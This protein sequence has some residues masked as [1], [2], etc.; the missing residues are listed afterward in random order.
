[1]RYRRTLFTVFLV[2]ATLSRA[3][4][5][6]LAR[7]VHKVRSN[8]DG[9]SLAFRWTGLY[10]GVNVGGAWGQ[11]DWSAG[12][13]FDVSGAMLGGTLGY[14]FQTS[15]IVYGL[16]ADLSW[17]NIQG[18]TTASVCSN[19]C[20]TQST[21]LGTARARVGYSFNRILAYVTGGA[22]FGDIDASSPGY[23]GIKETRVGW[24]VGG[25]LEFPLF[26]NTSAKVEYLHVDLGDVDCGTA[27]GPSSNNNVSLQAN[28]FRVGLNISFGPGDPQPP[29]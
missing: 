17:A 29:E 11:S 9:S 13:C 24:T 18:N 5:A 7:P 15:R 28:I 25:G 3:G 10:A 2:I 8:I 6:E 21:W 16:E 14:N 27:C 4:A 26:K 22:A 1:M 12:N 19:G 20:E 23:L